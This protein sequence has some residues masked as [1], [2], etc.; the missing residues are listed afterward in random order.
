MTPSTSPICAHSPLPTLP[1]PQAQFGIYLERKRASL[2]R[3][4]RAYAR[5]DGSAVGVPPELRDV[6][7]QAMQLVGAVVG[8]QAE[9]LQYAR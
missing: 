5:P 7:P 8:V 2:G 4:L 9:V 6:S 3:A 1:T